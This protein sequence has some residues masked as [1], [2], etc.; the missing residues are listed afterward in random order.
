M[1]GHAYVLNIGVYAFIGLAVPAAVP[2]TAQTA[3]SGKARSSSDTG[4]VVLTGWGSYETGQ[5]YHMNYSPGAGAN[6]EYDIPRQWL[7]REQVNLTGKYVYNEY[8]R[9]VVGITAR[10]WYD[11]Y[12]VEQRQNNGSDPM[13]SFFTVYPSDAQGIFS[14]NRFDN[15]KLGLQAGYFPFTYDSSCRNLGE[16]LFRSGTYPP[17]LVTTLD[18]TFCRLAGVHASVTLWDMV[19]VHALLTQE[20]DLPSFFDPSLSF[21]GDVNIEKVFVIG[22]G[23]MVSR[24]ISIDSAATSSHS[25]ATA[26][27]NPSLPDS[28]G[29]Y[30]FAGT[31]VMAR[32]SLDPKPLF[33][34]F[35]DRFLG[36]NDLK[37]Y[38]EAV[39]LGVKD[40]PGYYSNV[41]E[42]IPRM[43]GFDVPTFKTLDVL[44]AEVE[45]N[46]WPY[47]NGD[48]NPIFL[49]EAIPEAFY[50][51]T[52]WKWTIYAKRSFFRHFFILL[53]FAN[54]H[55][56]LPTAVNTEY[57]YEDVCAWPNSWYWFAR[58]GV[59][60]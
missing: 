34:S 1:K 15:V 31:K 54:D 50:A 8:F 58:A 46:P 35:S 53:Q 30:T 42:R 18:Q 11:E 14:Y 59:N 7:M 52:K 60:F 29:Y 45:Y 9:A 33:K 49:N 17:F 28:T 48:A 6:V 10:M 5:L 26:Y 32:A 4:K 51:H 40:Y 22:G 56:V 3:D 2:L 25:A 23:V 19:H 57:S 20:A 55:L 27:V 36:P 47:V 44:A 38:S 12:P 21:L 13:T 24:F 39:I 41:R 43:A 16:Y 37:I